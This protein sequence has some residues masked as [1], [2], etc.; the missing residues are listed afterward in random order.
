MC[1][2]WAIILRY[3]NWNFIKYEFEG[4]ELKKHC[5]CEMHAEVLEGL[6]Q[7]WFLLLAHNYTGVASD[8]MI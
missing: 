5:E 7:G 1:I 3:L 2:Y 4:T 8:T 6:E